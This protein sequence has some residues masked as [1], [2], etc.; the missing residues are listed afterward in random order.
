MHVSTWLWI[1]LQ[2]G[3]AGTWASTDIACTTLY[4]TVRHINPA[5][6]HWGRML[7][8]ELASSALRRPRNC[9]N[10]FEDFG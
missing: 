2:Q 9:G 1:V 8:M 3:L 7:T 5:Q 6:H 10:G 4:A